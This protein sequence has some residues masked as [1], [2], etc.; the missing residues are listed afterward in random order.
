MESEISRRGFLRVSLGA[1]VASSGAYGMIEQLATKPARFALASARA[2]AS[3]PREQY[4][5]YGTETVID[6]GV[7]VSVPP[8]YH[9]VV[10]ATLAS[11]TTAADLKAGH[12]A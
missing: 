9:E 5:F 1:A 2:S 4:L 8:L 6:N 10:T 12:T 3:L 11:A 7:G